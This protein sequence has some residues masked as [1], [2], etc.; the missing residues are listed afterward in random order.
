MWNCYYRRF[1]L[2]L[3][4]N[5]KLEKNAAEAKRK[6]R[7]F[8]KKNKPTEH[9]TSSW[10]MAFELC[11]WRCVIESWHGL[12]FLKSSLNWNNGIYVYLRI[13]S[14]ENKADRK[15]LLRLH[16]IFGLDHSHWLCYVCL[17][18]GCQTWIKI[19]WQVSNFIILSL[20]VYNLHMKTSSNKWAWSRP[21]L[22]DFRCVCICVENDHVYF[23]SW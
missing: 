20:L 21:Y 17:Q 11:V 12:V 14:I 2:Y 23:A 13:W 9:E 16:G 1:L 4:R 6:L 3:Q 22:P 10:E 5:D 18:I 15:T 8:K 7:E 19:F